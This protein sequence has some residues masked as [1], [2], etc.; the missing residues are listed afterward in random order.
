[1]LLPRARVA[2]RF[3]DSPPGTLRCPVIRCRPVSFFPKRPRRRGASLVRR[4][5]M[6]AVGDLTAHHATTR[7]SSGVSLRSCVLQRCTPCCCAAPCFPKMRTPSAQLGNSVRDFL[8]ATLPCPGA[9]CNA[10]P[11]APIARRVAGRCGAR[12]CNTCTL[13]ISPRAL[14]RRASR[15]SRLDLAACGGAARVVALLARFSYDWAARPVRKPCLVVCEILC[16]PGFVARPSAGSQCLCR[17]LPAALRGDAAR[18]VA[19]RVPLVISPRA[20]PRRARCARLA[21]VS[22]MAANGP[23]VCAAPMSKDARAARRQ[24]LVARPPA[25]H[26]LLARRPRGRG[27]LPRC[28]CA[29]CH[30]AL[31]ARVLL[32]FCGLRRC[33]PRCGATPQLPQMLAS[34]PQVAHRVHASPPATLRC[35][36]PV[37]TQRICRPLSAASR[38]VAAR[39]LTARARRLQCQR[40]PRH[41]AR[42][43]R[44]SLRSRGLRQPRCPKMRALRA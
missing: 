37:V 18:D 17:P 15:A 36:P 33:G 10:K 40:A 26:V 9:C 34:C 6:S 19:T 32:R 42:L 24:R 5:D 1:M 8:P 35:R 28:H 22:L 14:R 29:P 2:S 4:C 20:M 21:P 23:R 43:A 41:V 7:A 12:L 30:Y 16:R 25:P 31:F 38:G 13:A 44:F 11:F 27:A 39:D 3:R